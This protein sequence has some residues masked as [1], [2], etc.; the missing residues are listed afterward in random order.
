MLTQGEMIYKVKE[1]TD[2]HHIS[3]NTG[4]TDQQILEYLLLFSL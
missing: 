4:F 2:K 3:D 1:Q